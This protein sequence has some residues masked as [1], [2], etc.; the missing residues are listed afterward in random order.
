V[1]AGE[2][3]I[4]L[5]MRAPQ[6]DNHEKLSNNGWWMVGAFGLAFVAVL[7]VTI[8]RAYGGETVE[9]KYRGPVDLTP[10]QW[11][12]DLGRAGADLR[13]IWEISI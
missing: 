13:V 7:L 6:N 1:E 2:K 11:C 12:W 3:V 10:F 9:V 8:F 5:T 4:E